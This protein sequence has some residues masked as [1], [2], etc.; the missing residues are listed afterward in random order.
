M[1]QLRRLSEKTYEKFMRECQEVKRNQEM[2]CSSLKA[3]SERL[4][5]VRKE[6]DKMQSKK[7]IEN[8]TIPRI[9]VLGNRNSGKT[10]LINRLS[11]LNGQVSV[12][13]ISTN[14]LVFNSCSSTEIVF[15]IDGC[16]KRA[17]LCDLDSVNEEKDLLF[18]INQS[19]LIIIVYSNNDLKQFEAVHDFWIPEVEKCDKSK[20]IIVIGMVNLNVSFQDVINRL[21]NSNSDETEEIIDTEKR[22]IH[23]LKCDINDGESITEIFKKIN[24]SLREIP[25]VSNKSCCIS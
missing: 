5:G 12:R 2:S 8:S 6:K 3:N 24:D 4:L 10:T 1:A 9:L 19:S 18:A 16:T 11:S 17:I 25:Q 20:T 7:K 14:S 22:G 23:Y 13:S 21:D 15:H